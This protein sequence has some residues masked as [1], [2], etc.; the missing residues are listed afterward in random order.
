MALYLTWLFSAVH[1]AA[2]ARGWRKASRYM[3]NPN[4]IIDA[5]SASPLA[6]DSMAAISDKG[7]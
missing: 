5:C 1:P 2:A 6:P 7:L 3:H 4:G